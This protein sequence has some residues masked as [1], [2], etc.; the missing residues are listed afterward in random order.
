[1]RFGTIGSRWPLKRLEL[2]THRALPRLNES[3]RKNHFLHIGE[4][5]GGEQ[6]PLAG[7][8][9]VQSLQFPAN[10][11]FPRKIDERRDELLPDLLI[12]V[13]DVVVDVAFEE[14]LGGFEGFGEGGRGLGV[15]GERDG[16]DGVDIEGE[17]GPEREVELDEVGQVGEKG[18][19]DDGGEREGRDGEQREDRCVLWE[20]EREGERVRR[21]RGRRGVGNRERIEWLRIGAGSRWSRN[22]PRN[23][24]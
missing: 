15:G 17:M 18:L 23:D 9:V 6:L 13:S 7:G 20:R 3:P 1:M 21:G 16:D 11:A 22:P 19:E 10:L 4:D 24:R 14:K 8:H 12:D 2:G 5:G